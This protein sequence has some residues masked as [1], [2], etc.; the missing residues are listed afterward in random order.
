MKKLRND[1][2]PGTWV[3]STTHTLVFWTRAFQWIP[4]WQDLDGFQNMSCSCASDETSLSIKRVKDEDREWSV[5]NVL[6]NSTLGAAPRRNFDF[7]HLFCHIAAK[8]WLVSCKW[9]RKRRTQRKPPPYPKS[10]ATF[11]LA[12]AEI[13][14]WAVVKNSKQS[15]TTP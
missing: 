4:K 8:S 14:T 7:R 13:R 3:L 15:I 12:P 6:N 2:N 9:W 1:W 5:Q 11:S 10:L